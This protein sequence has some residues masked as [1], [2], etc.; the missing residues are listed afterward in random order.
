MATRKALETKGSR[1]APV[2]GR[3]KK[4][5]K[6]LYGSGLAPIPFTIKRR[7]KVFICGCGQTGDQ[8]FC[9]DSCGVSLAGRE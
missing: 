9:D 3:R 4:G 5:T 7:E 6:F 8:P 1:G 2:D